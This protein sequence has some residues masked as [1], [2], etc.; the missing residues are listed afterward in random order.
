MPAF[1]V[2]MEK[3]TGSIDGH[4]DTFQTQLDYEPEHLR[5]FWD[6]VLIKRELDDGFVELYNKQFRFK[7]IPPLGTKLQVWYTARY[8]PYP[9]P[10]LKGY[11]IVYGLRYG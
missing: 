4:N 10:I 8:S 5:V 7:Q 2:K 1:P 3:P 9:S 6:G 11:G